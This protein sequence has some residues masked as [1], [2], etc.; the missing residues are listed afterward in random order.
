M[1]GQQIENSEFSRTFLSIVTVRVIL[2][3]TDMHPDYK[4]AWSG[5]TEN[6]SFIFLPMFFMWKFCVIKNVK[7]YIVFIFSWT[8]VRNVCFPPFLPRFVG[9][10]SNY[11]S[12]EFSNKHWILFGYEKKEQY[13]FYM[14]SLLWKSSICVYS[15]FDDF[16]EI[17][18]PQ[19]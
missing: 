6:F 18:G 15:V 1:N 16:M 10:D 14:A 17:L 8:N 3:M 4:L 19:I 7:N 9:A 5:W 2:L 12:L 11:F 13:Y